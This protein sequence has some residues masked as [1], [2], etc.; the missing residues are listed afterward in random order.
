MESTQKHVDHPLIGNDVGIADGGRI[1]RLQ[2]RSLWR[3]DLDRAVGTGTDRKVG[4]E[5]GF[6]DVV[7]R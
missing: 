2:D 6:D 4:V 1:L 5:Y 7:G 3:E